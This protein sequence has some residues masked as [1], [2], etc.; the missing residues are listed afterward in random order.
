MDLL[1]NDSVTTCKGT[2]LIGLDDAQTNLKIRA[3]FTQARGGILLIE[4]ACYLKDSSIE[5]AG[6]A[7]LDLVRSSEFRGKLVVVLGAGC[8]FRVN[9]LF[10]NASAEFKDCFDKRRIALPKWTGEQAKIALMRQIERIGIPITAQAQD[11][12]S[13]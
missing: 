12:L 1:P 9:G 4:Q 3:I 5:T 6:P 10:T 13:R 8:D 2:E 7:L 11:E